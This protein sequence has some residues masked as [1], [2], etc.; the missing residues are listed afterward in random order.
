MPRKP[1]VLYFVFAGEFYYPC[2]GIDDLVGVFKDERTALRTA[3]REL[4][5]PSRWV[6]V[7]AVQPR[8]GL[9]VIIDP[10][11]GEEKEELLWSSGR[12]Q[13]K[14]REQEE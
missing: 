7:V 14:P 13:R 5:D 1:L 10:E 3:K 8:T 9:M 4:K 6:Q 11:T 2:G 12:L